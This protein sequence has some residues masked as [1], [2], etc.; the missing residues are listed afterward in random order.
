MNLVREALRV[1][2]EYARSKGATQKV[3]GDYSWRSP[4]WDPKTNRGRFIKFL[5]VSR[6][7]RVAIRDNKKGRITI[8]I[9]G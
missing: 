9:G 2:E 1:A 6:D 7:G 5:G 8:E 4:L 3:V